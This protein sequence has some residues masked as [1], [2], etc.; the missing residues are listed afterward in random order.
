LSDNIEQQKFVQI[1]LW[2]IRSVIWKLNSAEFGFVGCLGINL[3]VL[4]LPRASKHLIFR[5]CPEPDWGKQKEMKIAEKQSSDLFLYL[6]FLSLTFFSWSS[7]RSYGA[8]RFIDSCISDAVV[9]VT[10]MVKHQYKV[11]LYIAFS[12]P[13]YFAD[14]LH[15][16][17]RR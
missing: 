13:I 4:V 5:R 14:V 10:F 11:S 2:S 7:A 12:L 8:D 9:H 17:M 15:F 16:Q 3:Q 6:S 1:P